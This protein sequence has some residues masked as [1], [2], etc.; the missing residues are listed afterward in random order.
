MR[1]LITGA[2]GFLGRNTLLAVPPSWE[3]VALYRPG[4]S[5]LDS[6]LKTHRLAHIQPVACDLTDACQVQQ[7]VDQ[8]GRAFDACLYLAGNTS[9]AFSLHNPVDD[10][11]ANAIG[12][13]NTLERWSFEH[14]VFLSSC[15]VYLGLTGVVGPTSAVAP[16]FP[17]AISKLASE[18]YIRAFAHHRGMPA[19]ATIVRL[20]SAFGPY[21]SS[22]RLY[23]RLVRRFALERNPHFTVSGDGE[24]YVDAM[25]V[26]DAVRALLAVLVTPPVGIETVDLGT[27]SR[28]RLNDFV[29]RAAHIFDLEAQIT[30]E[31]VS[32]GYATFIAD[33]HPFL[34]RYRVEP[35]ASIETGFQRLAAHLQQEVAYAWR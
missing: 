7:T 23:T 20:F 5:S 3:V 2:A 8:V 22:Q 35:E 28:E 27:G 33:P 21:E 4:T 14:F 15:A 1:L 16:R 9:A 11:T 24:N 10:L 19:H 12:L 32:T 34:E 17:Y 31:G 29:R 13:L 6:F 18:H 25:F 26:D 30:H